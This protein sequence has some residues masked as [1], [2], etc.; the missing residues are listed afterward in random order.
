MGN[1]VFTTDALIEAVTRTPSATRPASTTWAATSSRCS[2]SRGEANV[3]DFQDNDV[4]GRTDRDRGYWR[5]VGTLDSFYDAHMDLIS[6]HPVFNLYNYEWPIYTDA[7]PLAAGEVRARL[8]GRIGHAVDSIVSTGGVVSGASSRTR[9]CPRECRSTPGPTVTDSVLLDGVDVGRHA[10][11]RKAI[12]DKNVLVPEG[13]PDR[14]RPGRATGRAGS[15]SPTPAS[16]S[17][18]R[19]R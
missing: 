11:V 19:A 3:Y 18:A 5:D 14:R 7:R 2:S 16:S 12:L 9:S 1:Y 8:G 4:P 13:A 10:V 17:S 6:V 15:S